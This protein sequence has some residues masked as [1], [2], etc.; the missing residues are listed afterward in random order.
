MSREDTI[1]DLGEVDRQQ[2]TAAF[3]RPLGV[4]AAPPI[5][6]TSR[7]DAPGPGPALA[8]SL[9]LFVPGLGQ[10]VAGEFAWGLFYFTGIGFCAALL[11]ATLASLDRLFPTLR[12]LGV[13]PEALVVAVASLAV[14]VVTLHLAGILHAQSVTAGTQSL[15]PHPLVAGLASLLVPGWGQLLAGHRRRAALFLLSVWLLSAAW[16]LVI[17][18]G[19]RIVGRMGFALPMSIK[20]G[21]G[22]AVL[23]G[24]PFIVW[25]IAIYDAA[26]GAAH[27]RRG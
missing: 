18:T 11:W 22:P 26:A 7:P 4:K 5:R 3:S 8:G 12:L 1:Y 15:V 9:S 24:A 2:A 25:V 10:V 6:R 27:A 13:P 14:A 17:P 16:L 21:W 20:D 23:L 19:A